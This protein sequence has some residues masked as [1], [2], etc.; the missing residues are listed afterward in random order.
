MRVVVAELNRLAEG[1]N[2]ETG[3]LAGRITHALEE[4]G[5]NRP[6]IT[7]RS[8]EQR[9]GN[10]CQQGAEVLVAVTIQDPER[11]AQREG[12]VGARVAV[13]DREHVDAVEQFLLPE[14]AM[15]TGAQRCGKRIPVH[16]F[17]RFTR[18]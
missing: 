1:I 14:H 13:C 11:G 17:V 10:T 6:R 8:V 5:D 3:L 9:I 18:Q 7:P 4:L 2:R 16:V 15:D 12:E